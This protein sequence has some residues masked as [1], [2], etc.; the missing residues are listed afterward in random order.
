[1][2]TEAPP[3]GHEPPSDGMPRDATPSD[4]PP[5]ASPTPGYGPPP[6]YPPPPAPPQPQVQWGPPNV[7]QAYG[8]PYRAFVGY[9]HPQGITILILGILGLVVCQLTGPFAWVMGNAAL[10]DIDANP[11]AYSNRST[12]QA[13]RICGIIATAILV[14]GLVFGLLLLVAALAVPTS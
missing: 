4:A 2:S 5:G 6:G 1:M 9:E 7:A 10:R 13:G 8:S 14:L 11:A 3:P 12:V